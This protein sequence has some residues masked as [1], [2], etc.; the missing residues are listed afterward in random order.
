MTEPDARRALRA[1]TEA[2]TTAVDASGGGVE[3][4]RGIAIHDTRKD[5]IFTSLAPFEEATNAVASLALVQQRYGV[6]EAPRVTLQFV[7]EWL[8]RVDKPRFDESAFD[9]LWED[10]AAE[11][12]EPDWVFRAVANV[13]WLT[14]E[15]GRFDFGDGVSIRGRSFEELRALGFS[16]PI[17]AALSE[18][19]GSGLGTSS[20]VMLVET[21]APKSPDNFISQA[22]EQIRRRL[23]G[24]SARCVCS[25]R[26]TSVL[27][28]CG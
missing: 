11:L 14:A 3:R 26:V 1:L 15:G 18:D 2:A 25:R 8:G 6:D 13:R 10:F 24:C 12:D 19:F 17:L 5:E 23:G 22:W 27:V 4:F 20:Y 16:E 9:Q 28:V 21:R 7:Y